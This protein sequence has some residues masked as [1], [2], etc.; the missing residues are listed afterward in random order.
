M[1]LEL[2]QLEINHGCMYNAYVANKF[3]VIS[4][5]RFCTKEQL[6]VLSSCIGINSFQKSY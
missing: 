6:G 3:A 1:Y 5:V 2:I 4:H